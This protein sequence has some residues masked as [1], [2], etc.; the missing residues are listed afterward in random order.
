MI[1]P[2]IH[3]VSYALGNPIYFFDL[4]LVWS[5]LREDAALNDVC[6]LLFENKNVL[7]HLHLQHFPIFLPVRRNQKSSQKNTK[8]M[9][10]E[11]MMTARHAVKKTGDQPVWRSTF[12]HPGGGQHKLDTENVHGESTHRSWF[13]EFKLFAWKRPVLLLTDLGR[14]RRRLSVLLNWGITRWVACWGEL[15]ETPPRRL[16]IPMSSLRWDWELK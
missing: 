4:G 7:H 6:R 16:R 3:S 15:A 14:Q 2:S 12:L 1:W 8:E 13:R 10:F 5:L 11:I 9:K